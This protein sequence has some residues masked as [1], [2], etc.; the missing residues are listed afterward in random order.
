MTRM[1][2]DLVDVRRIKEKAEKSPNFVSKLLTGVEIEYLVTK[3]T[4]TAKEGEISPYFQTLAG[5]FAS[6]EAFLKALGI[7]F[8][9]GLKLKEIE[10]LHDKSGAPVLKVDGKL[11]DTI[12]ALGVKNCSLSISHDGNYAIAVVSVE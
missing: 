5:F 6:K 1:G 10:V 2:V 3:P 7:G 8:S 12:D 11:K 9:T 4:K